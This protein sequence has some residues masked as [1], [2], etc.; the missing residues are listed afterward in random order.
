[1]DAPE[2]SVVIPVRNGMPWLEEQLQAVV[3][4]RCEE[5]WEVVVSD[6]GSTDQSVSFVE[7]LIAQGRPIRLVD[8]SEVYGPG[9]TRNV[10]VKAAKGGLI[11]FCDADDVVQPGWLQACVRSLAEAEATAGLSDYWS[12]NGL[13]V[14]EPA[15]PRPPPAKAQFGFL[16]AAMSSNLAVR[17]EV[18]EQ[19]DGFDEALMVGEDTDLCWRIQLSGYRFALSDAVVARRERSTVSDVFKRYVAYGRCGPVLYRRHKSSGL[20]SEPRAAFRAWAWLLLSLPRLRRSEFRIT[21]VEI[22]GWRCGR[23]LESVK[24]GVF[25]P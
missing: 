6:N 11:A 1:M 3:H 10:G 12:L 22:A 21:W 13:P 24:Q 15:I 19:L 17:R 18:F 7:E 23:L 8:A 5:A 9:A 20:K 16:D 14:P 25:F 4:Q 2:I